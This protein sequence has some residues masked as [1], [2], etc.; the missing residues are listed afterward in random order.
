MLEIEFTTYRKLKFELQSKFPE[1][2]FVIIIGN[3]VLGVWVNRIDALKA[4][5]EEC[6]N[7]DFL[8]KKI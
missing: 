8:I 7:F 4:A 1:G 6:G 3:K 5:Y 2:G